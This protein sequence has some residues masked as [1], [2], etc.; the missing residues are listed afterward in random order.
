MIALVRWL[1]QPSRSRLDVALTGALVWLVGAHPG[2]VTL[3]V[4]AAAA[5]IGVPSLS[6]ALRELAA[7]RRGEES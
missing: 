3:V 6:V 5:V 1:T 7:R 4:I 2:S